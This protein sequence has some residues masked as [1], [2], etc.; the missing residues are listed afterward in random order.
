MYAL[1]NYNNFYASCERFF[2]PTLCYK[3]I[4]VLINNDGCVVVRSHEAKQFGIPIEAPAFEYKELFKKHKVHA[5]SSNY[6]LYCD[7]SNRVTPILR[8]YTPDLEVYYIDKSF[9]EI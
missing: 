9:Y 5:F 4:V 8:K 6:S 1:V 2:N 3:P 7:M